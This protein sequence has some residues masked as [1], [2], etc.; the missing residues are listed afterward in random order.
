MKANGV[1]CQVWITI[2]ETI[3]S[4]GSPSQFWLPRPALIARKS[5]MPN[6]G[7]SMKV[8]QIMPTTAG[9]STT[10]RMAMRRNQPWPRFM[11]MTSSASASPITTCSTTVEPV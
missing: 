11:S 10:G 7:A 4:V 2:T 1:H 6:S 3:A 8:R 9:D 5:T